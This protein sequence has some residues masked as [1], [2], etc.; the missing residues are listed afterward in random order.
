MLYDEDALKR[1]AQQLGI[2][3]NDLEKSLKVQAVYERFKRENK[4]V[5]RTQREKARQSRELEES[6]GAHPDWC[7]CEEDGIEV[8]RNYDTDEVVGQITL[9]FGPHLPENAYQENVYKC[10]RCGKKY[11]PPQPAWA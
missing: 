3:V 5:R 10:D 1:A 8:E 9:H 2:S 4:T 7:F 11:I 6:K